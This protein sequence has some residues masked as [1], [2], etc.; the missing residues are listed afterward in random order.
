MPTS[1][2]QIAQ[3]Q[4][5]NNQMYREVAQ[6]QMDFQ[7]EMSNTAHVRETQDLINAGLNPVLSAGAQGASTP[8]GAQAD[9]DAQSMVNYLINE[10]NNE[11]A[12]KMNSAQVAAQKYAADQAL[13]AAQVAAN[14]QM[15]AA[16]KTANS[17]FLGWITN[18]LANPNS[19]QARA[20]EVVMSWL[21]V[22]LPKNSS[23]AK[24]IINDTISGVRSVISEN[25]AINLFESSM[26][27]LIHNKPEMDYLKNNSQMIISYYRQLGYNRLAN[28]FSNWIYNSSAR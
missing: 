17:S 15:Y 25:K 24:N 10:M 12:A 16:D 23:Q 13:R 9:V 1:A 3:L 6:A 27:K 18:A 21:G 22:T 19:D 5:E 28:V 20:A 14:A 4:R 7:R 2:E 26:K 8:N 11:N